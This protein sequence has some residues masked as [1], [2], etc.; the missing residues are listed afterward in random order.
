MKIKH[1]TRLAL[2]IP[3]YSAR[4]TRAM[5]RALAYSER[6]YVYRIE[7][8]NGIVG[9]GDSLSLHD[10]DQLKGHNPFTLMH[11]DSI[12]FGP[13]VAILDAVGKSVGAPVHALLG[14][15]VRNRCP[16]SWWDI[17]MPPE[18]WVAEAKES[19]KRGYTSF[20]MK[21]RPWRDIFQQ[22]EAVGKVVPADYKFDIDFNGFLLNEPWAEIVLQQLGEHPNV[23]IFESPFYLERDI[24]GAKI[25]CERI[26]KPI[27]EHF[28]EAYLHANACDGFVIGVG[29]KETLRQATLV[30]SF[31]KPFWLQ[32]VGTGITTA[33]AMHLG[34]VLT[35]ARLPYITCHELWKH[36]LLSERF[37]VVD[38]YIEVPEAPGLGIEVDERALAKYTVNRDDPTPTDLYRSKKRIFRITWPG[39]GKKK[40]VREFT[41][42]AVYQKEYYQGNLPGFERGVSLEV[43]ENDR[44][45]AF[46]KRHKQLLESERLTD[47]EL[48]HHS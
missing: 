16:I 14:R 2:N 11:V 30:T 47:L 39:D 10:P 27:V 21:A 18:D 17:D 41:D 40:R 24:P 36:D 1:A 35:H 3:F 13:Q 25:L 6:V 44:S 26:R 43:I 7:L 22:V 9:Y 28:N 12:G 31:N 34:S 38:G 45:S 19:L 37:K 8:D 46:N 5:N 32:L 15:K 4:V 20:K 33:F 29:V 48:F 23:G 42:E